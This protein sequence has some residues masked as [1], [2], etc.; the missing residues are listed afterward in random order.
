MRAAIQHVPCCMVKFPCSVN[1]H[2][3][4]GGNS[5]LLF[6]QRVVGADNGR[7]QTAMGIALAL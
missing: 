1:L 3:E 7:E 6:A 4:L 5:S 2:N